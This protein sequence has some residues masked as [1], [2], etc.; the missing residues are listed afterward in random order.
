MVTPKLQRRLT[1]AKVQKT[2]DLCRAKVQ[3]CALPGLRHTSLQ[4]AHREMLEAMHPRVAELFACAMAL[5]DIL[6]F[7]E[8]VALDGSGASL[9]P[10]AG[11]MTE[12]MPPTLTIAIAGL[13]PLVP[14]ITA[15]L[16]GIM[17][18]AN[19]LHPTLGAG[20][21]LELVATVLFYTQDDPQA[22]RCNF[23][24]RLNVALRSRIRDNAKPY[25]GYLRML[26][27]ALRRLTMHNGVVY[28]GVAGIDLTAKFPIDKRVR[29]WEVLSASKQK[30]VAKLFA[31]HGSKP[32]QTLLVIETQAVA[33]LG[34]LSLF[35]SEEECLFAPGS[36]FVAQRT[37]PSSSVPGRTVIYLTHQAEDMEQIYQ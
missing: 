5:L 24:Q 13:E 25:F 20:L 32:Q 12:P 1:V 4:P 15:Y 18:K 29:V 16:L 35:P 36:A 37:R 22:T 28:R 30:R 11:V 23:Y 6:G 19:A 33:Y 27:D 31:S 10:V 26:L 17:Q 8:A 9:N 7:E 21:S 34:P 14:S 2:V 3:Y